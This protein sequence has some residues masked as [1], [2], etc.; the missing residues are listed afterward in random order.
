MKFC[1]L[2]VTTPRSRGIP[3]GET[4]LYIL[5]LKDSRKARLTEMLTDPDRLA[6]MSRCHLRNGTSCANRCR[7]PPLPMTLRKAFT[8]SGSKCD[9]AQRRS[10]A[11]ASSWLRA[12]L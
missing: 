7:Y 4:R 2:T 8:T 5:C 11:T 1:S 12:S 10:S 3:A 6:Q 9:P